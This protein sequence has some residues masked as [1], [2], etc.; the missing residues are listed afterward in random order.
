VLSISRKPW[1]GL[2]FGTHLEVPRDIPLPLAVERPLP[3]AAEATAVT[4]ATVAS[5]ARSGAA[6][7][8]TVSRTV[9]LSKGAL[10][11]WDRRVT[12]AAE[13]LLAR[14][15]DGEPALIRRLSEAI[16]AGA[17]VYLGN[18]LPIREWNQFASTDDRGLAIGESRGANGIDGQVSTFLGWASPDRENWAVLGDLTALYDLPALWALRHLENVRV[19]IVVVNNGGG[20]IFQR[21]FRDDRFQNRHAIG[22]EAWASLWGAEYH[23]GLPPGAVGPAAIIELRP[24]DDQTEAFWAQLAAETRG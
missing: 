5:A 17:F 11:D 3:A 6:G 10:F 2:T 20:R 4:G 22:F 1:R 12:V 8:A 15:P 13:H 24:D 14:F 23:A 19:R 7:S 9:V 21:L 18:S 16:P